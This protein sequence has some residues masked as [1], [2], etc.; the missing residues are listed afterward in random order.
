MHQHY[1]PLLR[2]ARRGHQLLDVHLVVEEVAAF[3]V[4]GVLAPGVE[5][6]ADMG[7]FCLAG[8]MLWVWRLATAL[9]RRTG[10]LFVVSRLK[11]HLVGRGHFWL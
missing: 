11:S 4:L 9:V 7:D 1:R 10:G 5:V 8:I 2:D 3:S 6:R